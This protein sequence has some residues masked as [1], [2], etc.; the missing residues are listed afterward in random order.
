M[1]SQADCCQQAQDGKNPQMPAKPSEQECSNEGLSGASLWQDMTE[2]NEKRKQSWGETLASVP[3][4]CSRIYSRAAPQSPTI[5]RFPQR[6][7]RLQLPLHHSST[8][9]QQLSNHV[10]QH[11]ARRL[12]IHTFLILP[13]NH[14]QQRSF[15]SSLSHRWR[16]FVALLRATGAWS[17]PYLMGSQELVRVRRGGGKVILLGLS[18]RP[19]SGQRAQQAHWHVSLTTWEDFQQ[20]A[21]IRA[22]GFR[23]GDARQRW[24]KRGAGRRPD[25]WKELKKV[26][27]VLWRC[28]T[29]R[30]L[31]KKKSG[32]R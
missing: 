29:N 6:V 31:S 10:Q 17:S 3:D 32:F 24:G 30:W 28:K 14:N 12:R 7:T 4:S 15:L 18:T 11:L 5:S 21:L 8:K 16:P 20:L 25:G 19:K 2:L 9:D 13:C 22:A 23:W 26:T 1:R 27:E